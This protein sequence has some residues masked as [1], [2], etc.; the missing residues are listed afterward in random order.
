[1]NKCERDFLWLDTFNK[2]QPSKMGVISIK[3]YKIYRLL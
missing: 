1:M 3:Q 2:N